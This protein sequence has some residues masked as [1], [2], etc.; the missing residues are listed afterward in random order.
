[1]FLDARGVAGE[2]PAVCGGHFTAFENAIDNAGDLLVAVGFGE[3]GG[4]VAV[5]VGIEQAKAGEVAFSPELL[6]CG[7][8][9][10]DARHTLGDGLDDLVGGAGRFD[11]PLEV[12]G[13]IDDE[14]VPRAI[15]GLQ[16][17][18]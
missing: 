5:A 12:V 13:L 16:R 14:Q 17:T 8:E 11:G 6:R 1:M 9:Q 15:G 4:E 7:G 3:K 2:E 10:Q 18:F